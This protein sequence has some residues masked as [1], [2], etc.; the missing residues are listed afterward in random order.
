MRT[1]SA[2][3]L[4]M[5]R[6]WAIT[7]DALQNIS[8]IAVRQNEDVE[9]LAGRLG[10][11]LK[12][13]YK[14]TVHG[15]V[16]VL[17][18]VGPVF[19]KANMMTEISGA[20]SLSLLS[21]DLAELMD[22]DAIDAIILDVDS[23]GGVAFGPAEFAEQVRAA[24]QRKP[25]IAYVG[26]MAC[27]AAYWIAAAATE[28]VAHKTSILGSIGVVT[29]VPYQAEPDGNG[30]MYVEVV[31]SNAKN[32]RPDPRTD[33]G[34]A[35]IRREL[36]DL[37]AEF[38]KGVAAYRGVTVDRV[39]SDFGKGGVL[40]AADAVKVGMAD[41][42][43]SFEDVLADLQNRPRSSIGGLMDPKKTE[44]STAAP[45]A[46]TQ[47]AAPAATVTIDAEAIKT[48]AFAAGAKA[49][50]ER[51]LGIEAIAKAGHEKLI[52]DAKAD[53][54]STAADV[55]VKIIT[56]EKAAGVKFV[57]QT[58]AATKETPDVDPGKDEEPAAAPA[59]DAPVETR[60]EHEFKTNASIRKEF[61][62]LETYTA[63]KKGEESGDIRIKK[64]A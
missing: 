24:G 54:T 15:N 45:E 9:V 46:V 55:A 1:T 17:P 43:G 58:I 63:F 20:T 42:V 60:A 38:V 21:H 14:S 23:P 13:T 26:G 52:A 44:A 35:E 30:D 64:T 59:E 56:A 34:L 51:I 29:A 32:K 22:N 53:G 5:Q 62:S 2:I 50:R 57:Q 8:R 25:V 18:L 33:A 36:D 10:Q 61:G 4:I 49:E 12:Y 7:P 39:L 47:P 28:I 27:S 41:R 11:P 3:D 19:P 6:H 16:A 40:I 48:D 31:S 37:E